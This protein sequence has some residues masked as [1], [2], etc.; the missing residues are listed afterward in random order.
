MSAP[1][2]ARR[3]VSAPVIV[4]SPAFAAVWVGQVLTQTAGRMAQVGVVWWLVSAASGGHPGSRAGILL[5]VATLPAVLFVHL[6]SRLIARGRH[7]R[8][9]VLACLGAAV[10]A[11]L[12]TAA[13]VAGTV[14]LVLACLVCLLLATCQA[15]FDPCV[16]TSVPELVEDRDIEAATG[17]ELSTQSA[18]GLA[19]GFLGPV[20]V[21]A[22]GVTGLFAACTAGYLVAAGVVSLSGIARVG[23]SAGPR[24]G[25]SSPDGAGVPQ[26]ATVPDPAA[27]ETPTPARGPWAVLAAMPR[28]RTI[29]LCFTA[30]NL[31]TTAVFV[32]MPLF[33]RTV[34][35]GTGATASLFEAA[36]GAGTILGAA[37]G[38]SLRGRA[39]TTGGI[40]L[41]V[42]AVSFAAPGVLPS[43]PVTAA[44]LLV[45]GW[46]IGAIGVRFVSMFQR[47]VPAADK[48]AFFAV[49]QALVS[50]TLPVASLVFGALG[51]VVDVRV[52][53]VVQGVG[54][55]PVAVALW[56]VGRRGEVAR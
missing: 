20:V 14:P 43:R 49:M 56:A 3:R 19:G 31:F 27:P 1:A 36:L 52:L 41:G 45:A 33:A 50:A 35:H 2:A 38:S 9:L 13:S 4:R 37:T 54:L 28:I 30:A 17:F 25:T 24:S 21:D 44:G 47:T 39:T 18:A 46:C 53:W 26:S 34:L 40:C 22:V 5:T 42:A 8:T 51:D 6:V 23:G 16:T 10:V 7:R 15:V 29:L 12:A 48:P 55:V 32:V 11:A